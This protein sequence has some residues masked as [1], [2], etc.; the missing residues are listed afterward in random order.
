MKVTR[1]TSSRVYNESLEHVVKWRPSWKRSLLLL[2]N[3]W[4]PIDM[5]KNR[6]ESEPSTQW[7]PPYPLSPFILTL[8]SLLLLN[9][10]PLSLP[11]PNLSPNL[12]L[13]Q[14]I[15]AQPSVANGCSNHL[16]GCVGVSVYPTVDVEFLF[17]PFNLPATTNPVAAINFST[18][19]NLRKSCIG[20]CQINVFGVLDLV[21]WQKLP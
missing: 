2:C 13:P 21:I 1:S 19:K 10:P 7:R 17:L 12:L 16:E 6:T 18:D 14:P 5:K 4:V 11:P 8:L 3:R 15:V 9:L 20:V